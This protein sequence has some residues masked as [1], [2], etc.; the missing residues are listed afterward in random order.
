MD[1]T[2]PDSN[3]KRPID[4]LRR[5]FIPIERRTSN[6]TTVFKTQDKMVYARL[7]DGSIRRAIPKVNGKHAK[8]LRAQLRAQVRKAIK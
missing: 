4:P 6:G 5:V 7:E 8:K 3:D 1:V 2:I